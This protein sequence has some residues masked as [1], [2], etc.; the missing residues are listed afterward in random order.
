[1][2]GAFGDLIP[3]L[4]SLGSP[5]LYSPTVHAAKLKVFV[6]LR[7]P[8]GVIGCLLGQVRNDSRLGGTNGEGF[9]AFA[10]CA[11]FPALFVLCSSLSWEYDGSGNRRNL[12]HKYIESEIAES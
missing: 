11:P 7:W 2:N 8:V 4:L 12:S 9:P 10:F 3:P 6:I 1:M 5:Y